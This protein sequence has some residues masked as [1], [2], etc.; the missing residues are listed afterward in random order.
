[1]PFAIG[2]LAF[3]LAFVPCV[4]LSSVLLWFLLF[5]VFFLISL[6][7]GV[8]LFFCIPMATMFLGP[9]LSIIS[10]HCTFPL[11][12]RRSSPALLLPASVLFDSNAFLPFSHISV[13][14]VSSLRS[15]GA[16][17]NMLASSSV[18]SVRR[19]VFGVECKDIGGSSSDVSGLRRVV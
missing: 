3:A 6:S 8:F 5:L 2:V 14:R 12:Y 19:R 9:V 17:A 16:L 1:M 15:D 4:L 18:S 10:S 7:I 11:L 13:W